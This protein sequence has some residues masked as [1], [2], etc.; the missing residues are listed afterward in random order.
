MIALAQSLNLQVIAEGVETPEQ[1]ARLNQFGCNARFD[2]WLK[3]RDPASG[4]RD[5]A[6]LQRLAAQADMA[7]SQDYP[8]PVNN[9]ILAWQKQ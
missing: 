3:Q 1:L 9:R 5:V 6:E 8:M 7:L 4:L 2:Q